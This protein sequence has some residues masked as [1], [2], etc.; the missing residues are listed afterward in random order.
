VEG[1]KHF[2]NYHLFDSH[3]MTEEDHR[4]VGNSQ[5]DSQEGSQEEEDSLEA[6]DFQEE[7]DTQVEVEY[8][9]EDHPEEVGDRHR[10]PFPKP[11][12]ENW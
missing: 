9:P 8:H 10:P 3:K 4:E 11:S 1:L 12:Q 7:V 5:E 6:E 2:Q